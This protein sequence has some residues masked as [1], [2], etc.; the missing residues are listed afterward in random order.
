MTFRMGVCAC[1]YSVFAV[2]VVLKLIHF[3]SFH[4]REIWANLEPGGLPFFNASP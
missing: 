2:F 1:L 3:M 4:L